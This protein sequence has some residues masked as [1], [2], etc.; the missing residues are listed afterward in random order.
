ME[1]Q[2]LLDKLSEFLMVEQGG[3]QLYRVAAARC[4]LPNIKQRYQ[5]FGEQTARHREIYV[6][7]TNG[8][9]N[10]NEAIGGQGIVGGNGGDG[11]GGG[12]ANFLGSTL[13]VSNCTR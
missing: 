13:T 6:T 7:V 10:H 8:T 12:V 1:Q 11:L 3:L 4:S 9:I 5:E 2:V